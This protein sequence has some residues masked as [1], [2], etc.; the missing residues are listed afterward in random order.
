MRVGARNT[1]GGTGS[2]WVAR[3]GFGGG[4]IGGSEPHAAVAGS[5][6]CCTRLLS[7]S[8]TVTRPL[9]DTEMPVGSMN[10]PGP[11]PC[12][13]QPEQRLPVGRERDHAVVA[14]VGH[15][16]VAGAVERDLGG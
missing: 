8:A 4:V 11:T 7:A 5:W 16:H 13:P 2:G 15:E 12:W 3:I 10:C 6:N 14:A 9:Q 1:S